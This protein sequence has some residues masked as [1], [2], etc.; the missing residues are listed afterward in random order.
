MKRRF[1]V[2]WTLLSKFGLLFVLFLVNAFSL[3]SQETRASVA[4]VDLHVSRNVLDRGSL[5]ANISRAESMVGILTTEL[6]NSR[7][8]RVIERSRIDQIIREQGFQ[9]TQLSEAQV[10]RVGRILGVNYIITGEV[11][12]IINIRL[13][14]VETGEIVAAASDLFGGRRSSIDIGRALINDLLR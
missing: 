3:F 9:R 6:V 5:Y 8:F 2:K 10:V 4:I 14:N 12:H 13:I 7:R 11:S 1:I